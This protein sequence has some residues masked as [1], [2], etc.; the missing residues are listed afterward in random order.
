[1]P[2]TC[3]LV[4]GVFW[5]SGPAGP[6]GS[7]VPAAGSPAMRLQNPEGG[8]TELP[9]DAGTRLGFRLAAAGKKC[10]GHHVVHGPADRDHILCPENAPAVKGSQCERCFVMDDSRLIHDFHRG[11]RVPAGLRTYLMQ[12]HWLYIASFANGASKVGTAANLRKWKR[13][14]EQ[15]AVAARYVAR[16]DD[17]RVVR[18]LEDLVTRDAGIPQQIR[19][20]AKAAAL[21]SPA[22]AAE[23]DARNSRLA[24]EVRMLLAGAG[25][26]GFEVV[27]E[28]WLR[29]GLSDAVCAPAARHAYPQELSTGAHGFRID[30]LSGSVALARLDGADLEFIV[31]LGQLKAR[32][33]VLGDHGSC[34]PA[35]QESLF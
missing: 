8:F 14:A 1:M 10:L 34:V 21:V 9:L 16:A 17:G 11:G 7:A 5:D 32:T 23:L 2:D 26:G 20:A 30:S 13:L 33:I 25:G 12:P 24:A 28:R 29:P 35:V 3:Y 22:P 4:H 19:A 31:N 6:A 27:E 15:G 18:L